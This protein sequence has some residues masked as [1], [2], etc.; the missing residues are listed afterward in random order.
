MRYNNFAIE[1]NKNWLSEAAMKKSTPKRLAGH[2]LEAA[3]Q[4]AQ[5]QADLK[6]QVADV[7]EVIEWIS[8]KKDLPLNGLARVLVLL[9]NEEITDGIGFPRIDT[10][11]Y[12]DGKWARWSSHVTH[13]MPLPNTAYQIPKGE[14]E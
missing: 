14:H 6:A 3:E 12:I 9:K 4:I 2:L 13:W 1:Q 10:D 7:Q 11:R 5:L 8:V